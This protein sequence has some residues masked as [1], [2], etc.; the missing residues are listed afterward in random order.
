MRTISVGPGSQSTCTKVCRIGPIGLRPA[1]PVSRRRERNVL[2][3]DALNTLYL[4]LYGVR[5][6]VKDHSDSER[7]NPLPSHRLLFPINSKVFF[8]M[9]HPTDRITHTTAFVTPFVEHTL[10]REIA[11]WVHHEGSIRRPIAPWAN[12]LTMELRLAPVSQ[13]QFICGTLMCRVPQLT[14]TSHSEALGEILSVAVCL[15][16]L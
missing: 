2:F 15:A 11:Q 8:Y 9:H 12:A 16:F 13:R 4:R 10:V 14:L 7:G 1:L 3:N 6:M 5:H